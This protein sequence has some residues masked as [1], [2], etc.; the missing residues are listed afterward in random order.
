M[1]NELIELCKKRKRLVLEALV[2]GL[3]CVIIID[4]S[5]N[6]D[7]RE[8]IVLPKDLMKFIEKIYVLCL[9]D[10]KVLSAK[11][12]ILRCNILMVNLHCGDLYLGFSLN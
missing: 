3:A 12:N 5:F 1:I 2:L 6:H 11:T 9:S 7:L 10:Q 8:F 4:V